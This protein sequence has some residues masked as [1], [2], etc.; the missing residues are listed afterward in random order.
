MAD[1]DLCSTSASD[2]VRLL[3]ARKVSPLE[4]MQAVLAR[5]DRI[6]PALNAY[7]AVARESA[8]QERA[9]AFEAA[10]P[11]AEKILPRARGNS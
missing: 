1:R 11:C 6:N 8:L 10:A 7:V 4:A 3:R 2:L 5:I 9:A